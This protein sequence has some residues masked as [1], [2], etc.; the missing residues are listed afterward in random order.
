MTV[1]HAKAPRMKWTTKQ[2]LHKPSQDLVEDGDPRIPRTSAEKKKYTTVWYPIDS[3]A[4]VKEGYYRRD[5][6]METATSA[7]PR[8]TA[9]WHPVIGPVELLVRDSGP[10]AYAACVQHNKDRHAAVL[11]RLLGGH[12]QAL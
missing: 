10:K 8:Y 6:I 11:G 12:A 1:D 4:D 9:T 3:Q 7:T 2:W 5:I